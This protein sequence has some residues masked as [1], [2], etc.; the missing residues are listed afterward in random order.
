MRTENKVI[1]QGIAKWHILGPFEEAVQASRSPLEGGAWN[2]LALLAGIALGAVAI[3]GF[4]MYVGI[5]VKRA[6]LELG[7]LQA[8][9]MS[10]WHLRT[11]LAAEGFIM[12]AVGLGA[13]L[14]MG[15]W[16]GQWVLDYLGVTARGGTVVPPMELTLDG[17][18]L[19]LAFTEIALAGVLSTLLA[20][21]LAAR[22]RLHEVLRVEE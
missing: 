11:M 12:T 7:V 19:G 2:G 6:R 4:T 14:A 1:H 13:G 3:L 21:F 5:S 22:L 16:V 18:L 15:A 20:I 9:G 10:R 17:W 8:L